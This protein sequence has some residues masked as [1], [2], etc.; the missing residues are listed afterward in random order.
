MRQHLPV[1]GS[2]PRRPAQPDELR[3]G[4]FNVK[5]SPNLG[6]GLLSECLEAELIRAAPGFRV[7]A[8]DLAGR[9]DYAIGGRLRGA[10][11][12]LLQ[13]SPTP[14]R[15]GLA[16]TL[17]GYSL[18]RSR[19]V[20]REKLAG[21][22]V[23]VTGGGNLF[24]DADLNFPL[25]IDAAWG[26]LRAAGIPTAVFAVGVSDNWS[27]T[28]SDLFRRAFDG[29]RILDISVRDARSAE[30]WNR[31]LVPSGVS[32]ARIVHDPGLLVAH[33]VPQ[34]RTDGG[35][36]L[37]GLGLTHP[38]TL[39]YHADEEA[40]SERALTEWYV[41]LVRGCVG[42][43]WQ[44]GVFTN[45]SSEDEAYLR[46]IRPI[47][48]QA[49]PAS[50]VRSRITFVPRFSNPTELSTYISGLNLL[51]A[52][53]LH[54]NIAAYSY[55]VPQIGFTWDAKLKSFFALVGRDDYVRTAGR[56]PTEMVL[57]LAERGLRE[58]IDRV[59]HRRII[60]E[61][62]ADVGALAEALKSGAGVGAAAALR[63]ASA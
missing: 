12:S 27:E 29:T 20:W 8:F 54:A 28:G 23:A 63:E 58:G 46:R 37:I 11:L 38:T 33:H 51:M 44:V 62:R 39:R 48:A 14:V 6:D 13:N 3:V 40:V 34:V 60:D 18:R 15:H 41:E 47:L 30:V 61:A 50:G 42:R 59:Q 53:R 5:Y 21:I 55:A 35:P 25:K 10:A 7:H 17:L 26:E 1:R 2:S 31:R 57:A 19:T 43:G 45:G 49:D 22:D 24:S 4:L 52:H 32:R 36:P 9:T 56:E 16:R